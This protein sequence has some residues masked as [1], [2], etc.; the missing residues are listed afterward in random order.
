MSNQ[1]K[2]GKQAYEARRAAKAGMS[3]DHWLAR[4]AD[5]RKIASAPAAQPNPVLTQVRSVWRRLLDRAH[6]PL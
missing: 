1:D 2:Q 5:A 3:L 4:K 6:R